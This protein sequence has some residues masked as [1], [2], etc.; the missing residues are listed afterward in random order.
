MSNRV[1]VRELRQRASAVLKRVVN[2]EVIEVTDH[3]HPIAR[4]V[5]LRPGL[6][7]QLVLEGR[8]TEAMDDLLDMMDELG[9]PQTAEVG[10][11]LPSQALAEL[12]ADER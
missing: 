1:G 12:R 3:G 5:P 10:H 6:L 7:D 9:L 11:Q 8:A 4:I 2:G